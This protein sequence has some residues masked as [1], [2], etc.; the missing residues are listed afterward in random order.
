MPSEFGAISPGKH[1]L[2]MGKLGLPLPEVKRVMNLLQLLNGALF[3]K[4]LV[5][6]S[7]KTAQLASQ[8]L[9]FS[10]RLPSPYTACCSI[11][12]EKLSFR[13]CACSTTP[14]IL[15]HS[16][17]NTTLHRVVVLVPAGVNQP[18]ISPLY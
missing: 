7:E 4:A 13:K 1:L 10:T 14:F 2:K 8:V 6:H 3:E 5:R 18:H 9:L 17:T 15:H 12:N 16:A 11:P